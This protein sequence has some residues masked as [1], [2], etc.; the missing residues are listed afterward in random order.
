MRI[1]I[2]LDGCVYNFVDILR[3]AFENAGIPFSQ[4]PDPDRYEIWKSWGIDRG[5]F[6]EI[7]KQAET[8]G[9]F[10]KGHA[11][12]GAL[13]ALS[14]LSEQGHVIHVITH[15]LTA[16]A[17]LS[18]IGWLADNDVPY[19]QLTFSEAKTGFPVDIYIEDNLENA[20]EITAAGGRCVLM[21]RNWN[22]GKGWTG[23]VAKSWQDFLDII[24]DIPQTETGEVRVVSATGGEKGVKPERHSMVPV[25]PLEEVARVY[26]YG[27]QKYSRENWRQGYPW[28]WSYDSL[29]RHVKAFWKGQDFDPDSG[30]QHLAHACFHLFTLMTFGGDLERYAQ[31]D[32]RVR[33]VPG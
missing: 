9:V 17:Q 23:P 10:H 4:M 3:V 8:D 12:P 15:R 26:G 24:E 22:R 33:E 11:Y 14:G 5:R 2:D 21:D 18:T 6:F 19:D 25:P 30:Y 31:H 20:T 27:A 28:S 16:K 29:Q 7:W 32:D 13:E 1:G